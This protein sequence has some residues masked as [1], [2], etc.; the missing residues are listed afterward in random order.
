MVEEG[1]LFAG[2]FQKDH[3]QFGANNLQYETGETG[4][5]AD[6]DPAFSL[7]RLQ[8]GQRSQRIQKVFGEDLPVASEAGEI[9]R[10]VPANQF[11]VVD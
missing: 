9:N 10:T 8:Q 6:I 7:H 4:A 5:G 2:C 1:D 3:L 11:S